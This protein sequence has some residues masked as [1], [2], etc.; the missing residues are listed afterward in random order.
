MTL[1][2]RDDRPHFGRVL[3][4]EPRD[5]REIADLVQPADWP[6]AAGYTRGEE[7]ASRSPR[8]PAALQLRRAASAAG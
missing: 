8:R 5:L 2:D 4:H 3:A 1:I 7:P 6:A